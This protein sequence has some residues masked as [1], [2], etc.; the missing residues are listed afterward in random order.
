M[1]EETFAHNV[2]DRLKNQQCNLFIGSGISIESNLPSW[3]DLLDPVLDD[4]GIKIREN[5][6]FPLLAQYIVNENAGN[7]NNLRRILSDAFS[8]SN[9]PNEYHEILARYPV[10]T[11]WTTNCDRL[12]ETAFEHKNPKVISVH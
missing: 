4:I 5:D 11:I 3:K 10:S 6:D 7:L 12:L 2:A 1:K 8:V 9:P